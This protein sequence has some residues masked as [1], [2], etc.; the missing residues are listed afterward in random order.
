MSSL[1][2]DGFNVFV[3]P[4]VCA[5]CG[6][7]EVLAADVCS[8]WRRL[9]LDGRGFNVCPG[10]FPDDSGSA[11]DFKSAYVRVVQVLRAKEER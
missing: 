6:R 8:N 7:E 9:V 2:G 4:H 11:D 1:F 10:H 5:I 3:G